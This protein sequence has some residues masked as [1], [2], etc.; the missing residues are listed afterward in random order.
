[1][2]RAESVRRRCAR[3]A[4]W[5]RCRCIDERARGRPRSAARSPA[6]SSTCRSASPA[7]WSGCTRSPTR[8]RRTR[9]PAARSP[10]T[11]S[12]GIAGF[13]PTTFHAH[14]RRGSRPPRSRRGFQPRCHQRA[15]PAVPAVRRR[16]AD[17]RDLPG[18]RRC[19]PATRW[20]SASRRTTARSST[21]SPPT[22]TRCPTPTCSASACAEALDELLDTRP[23]TPAQRAARA[24]ARRRRKPTPRGP[25]RDV[26]YLPT[27][28]E[29]PGR[30]R[31]RAAASPA[32]GDDVVRGR[33]DDVRGARS[34]PR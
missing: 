4:R 12:P 7:R 3:C 25:T 19:C 32:V 9:R 15:R 22:A 24:A 20:R 17:D 10:P 5:C 14:R 13:A 16:R 34:T 26:L 30:L 8:S 33:A 23:A 2:T 1:M 21:A 18:A 28:L 11:G 6:T 31:A 29:R 27:T